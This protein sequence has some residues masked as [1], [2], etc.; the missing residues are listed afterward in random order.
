L[1][2]VRDPHGAPASDEAFLLDAVRVPD[3]GPESDGVQ[4]LD[5]VREPDAVRVLDD[6]Q[7]LESV[8]AA[9]DDA[10]ELGLGWVPG[11]AQERVAVGVVDVV[12]ER[13]SVREPDGGQ[14]WEWVGSPVVPDA[15]RGQRASLLKQ[16]PSPAAPGFSVW[17][18]AWFPLPS[19]PEPWRP[20]RSWGRNQ[21][22]S[23]SQPRGACRG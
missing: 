18:S 3:G 20:R 15:V 14:A 10:Q 1:A 2:W 11:D 8:S 13:V 4:V 21:R 23:R 12:R 17:P 9:L 7:E 19:R 22:V 5:G 16:G 6:V